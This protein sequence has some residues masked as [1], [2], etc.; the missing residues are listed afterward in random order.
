MKFQ[1]ASGVLLHPTCLPG[2][3][4]IGELGAAARQFVDWLAE[5][6]QRYWQVM[7]LGPTGY[8]DSPYQSFSAFAGNPYLIDMA[9][10][11]EDGLLT[12]ADFADEPAFDAQRIDFGTQY[13]WRNLMLD[14]AYGEYLRSKTPLIDASFQ[15]FKTQESDWLDDYALFVALKAE[16]GGQPWNVWEPALRDRD[17]QALA[18]A[19][20]RLDLFINRVKFVQFLFFRQWGAL[21][22]YARE[23][24]VHIIGDI[25]IFVAMDSS[26]AW[27]NRDQFFFDEL[28]QPTVVAGV[29]PDYFS[30]T[31]QLW[32][33][34]LYNWEK[35]REND[36][37]WWVHRFRG[38]LKLYDIIRVDHFRGFA[39]YW[40]IPYPA[41][42]ALQ[43]R[44][45]P[46][47]GYEMF[48]AVEKALGVLPIIA[49]DLGVITPDVEKLRDDLDFPGMAVLQ[50]AFGGG[51]YA[52]NDFLPTNIKENRVAYTGTHDND[53]SRGW[54]V[55]AEESEREHF[56][57]F[58]GLEPTEED[59][60]W[61][62][63]KMAFET[64]ALLVIVP[65][66]D[67]LNLG[68]DSRM[69]LPG[70]SG[71]HNWT[72]RFEEHDLTHA[73]AAKLRELTL[74]TNRRPDNVY[75]V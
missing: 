50:F 7:P 43:G 65:L 14:R 10:L 20:E 26:D 71:P 25:P 63:T 16:H 61:T 54:W 47:L 28:G 42:T 13:H 33:N 12:D 1:R 36:F 17:P 40:E 57:E 68:S 34:P 31:G 46:A 73:S 6:G 38:S 60:T 8:G 9:T 58:S 53:T 51:D 75:T 24:G 32:G 5:A 70:T 29:P 48:R 49:E 66:Q 45:V 3:Y 67:V 19:R 74:A 18:A 72:W 55:N 39:G 37:G 59:F 2:P 22:V 30:E 62:L 56:R 23:R 69:N 11:R 41:E 44:W 4:G 64:R 15:V 21:R 52:I 27:A 35:M